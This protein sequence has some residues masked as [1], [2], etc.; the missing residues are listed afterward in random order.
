MANMKTCGKVNKDSVLAWIIC[1]W[2]AAQ[3]EEQLSFHFEWM[4]DFWGALQ[5][6]A[7]YRLLI[8]TLTVIRATCQKGQWQYDAI[9]PICYMLG[10]LQCGSWL[11]GSMGQHCNLTK[12]RERHNMKHTKS[13]MVITLAVLLKF[14]DEILVS[15]WIIIE[16]VC[17]QFTSV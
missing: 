16:N 12:E 11:R 5:R 13:N 8:S 15:H 1:I 6:T 4:K 2:N 3:K 14:W 7:K 17:L 9:C 10:A